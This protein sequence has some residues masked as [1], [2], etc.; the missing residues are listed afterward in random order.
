MVTGFFSSPIVGTME[1][2][3]GHCLA[4]TGIMAVLHHIIRKNENYTPSG[5]QKTEAKSIKVFG[6][7]V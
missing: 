7:K 4:K 1:G 2:L 6:K 3:G 5:L